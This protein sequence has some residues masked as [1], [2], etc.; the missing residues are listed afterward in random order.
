MT[1]ETKTTRANP[2]L[3]ECDA[4][5]LPERVSPRRRRTIKSALELIDRDTS[6]SPER[7][8]NARQRIRRAAQPNVEARRII[9]QHRK[10]A[11]P[12]FDNETID[13]SDAQELRAKL[14][15]RDG[16]LWNPQR[17]MI[18][19]T[20]RQIVTEGVTKAEFKDAAATVLAMPQVLGKGFRGAERTY[21]RTGKIA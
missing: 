7:R 6:L 21:R 3:P 15:R 12:N 5:A 13:L 8:R 16:G 9:E 17:R 14:I 2:P 18:K 20:E 10:E 11:L 4:S 19:N 1:Y